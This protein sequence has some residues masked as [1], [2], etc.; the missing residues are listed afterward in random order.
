MSLVELL[1]AVN[2]RESF[3]TRNSLSLQTESKTSD[4]FLADREKKKKTLTAVKTPYLEHR[5]LVYHG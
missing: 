3:H 2:D 1:P 4:Q 5:W